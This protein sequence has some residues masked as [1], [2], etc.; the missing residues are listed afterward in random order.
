MHPSNACLTAILP[1]TIG[2]SA[3]LADDW[4]QWRGADRD[5]V[6]RETGLVDRFEFEQ[7]E[8]RWR[9]PIG[10]GYSGPTVADGR[11]F[12]TDR[13]A[14]PE[15]VERVH[16]FDWKLGSKLW[17][18]SY[19]CEYTINYEAGPRASVTVEDNR[20][21]VLG[22]MGHLHCLDAGTGKVLWKRDLNQ[23]Y[24]ISK[25]RRMPI[26]GIAA[27]PL[28]YE[29]LVIVHIGAANNASIVAFDKKYGDPQWKALRDRA[30][31]S[32]PILIEQAGQTVMVC[33]TGDSVA[34]L[35]PATGKVFWRHPMA[36]SRMPIG[37][38]TPVVSGD[39]LFVTSFYDG[40]L[41]LRLR[42]DKPAVEQLW[43]RMGDSEQQTDALHSII[44]TPL[45][46]GDY[47]Y[48]TDSYGELRCLKAASGDRVWEDLT[49]TPKA[50]W[51]NLHFVQNGDRT[52]MFNERGELII[53]KLSPQGFD[54]I[55]RAKLIE[56]TRNQ[57]NKRGGVC[58]SHPAFA[59]R[60]IFIRNDKE[61]VCASLEA[62]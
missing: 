56:P 53:C 2:L 17:T 58:W 24:S 3:G 5:G 47:I 39:R 7:I 21:F 44:S 34:G 45:F 9:Q 6:W 48:G 8:I 57:L 50:R 19:P 51:S 27:A 55:S 54:E 22:A 61:I 10:P 41:M 46:M 30:Q 13:Q 16:C 25:N 31:Y 23:E 32:A 37:V 12:V 4:P 35:D 36:P 33:W 28:I 11:V 18:F 49:A 52:W 42:Q 26:W 14:Q 62:R 40:S 43:R 15:Q 29:D 1:L 60:H 20:A 59:N 38:A